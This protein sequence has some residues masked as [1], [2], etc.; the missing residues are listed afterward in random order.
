ME[1]RD[2]VTKILTDNPPDGYGLTA[3]SGVSCPAYQ[4]VITGTTFTCTLTVA[5]SPR[6]VILTVKDDD[7]KYEVAPP[8]TAPTGT[9]AT[10]TG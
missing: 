3:I 4:P 10:P 5:G 1:G 7:G 8:V 2:R 9:V 6:A